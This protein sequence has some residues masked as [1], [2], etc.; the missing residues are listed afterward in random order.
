LTYR[1]I[2]EI[3]GVEKF[4]GM[5]EQQPDCF[6]ICEDWIRNLSE[7]FLDDID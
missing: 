7:I 5:A 2:S 6:E 4:S 1:L 3:E